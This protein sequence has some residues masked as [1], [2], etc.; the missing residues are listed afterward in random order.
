M[1]TGAHLT[2]QTSNLTADKTGLEAG[3]DTWLFPLVKTAWRVRQPTVNGTV[4][5]PGAGLLP[6]SVVL[7][8]R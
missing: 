6:S 5:T 2:P 8:P 4:G 1:S 7:R 3:G